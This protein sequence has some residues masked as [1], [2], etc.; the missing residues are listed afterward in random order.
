[1]RTVC[2]VILAAL[3]AVSSAA[4]E[5]L[6]PAFARWVQEAD[7][8]AAE[9]HAFESYLQQQSVGDVLPVSQLLLNATSWRGCVAAPYS[10]P[11]RALWP[12]VV[13]T[14]RFIR[15]HI[16]PAL[17][18][19]S[20]VSGYR[21]PELNACAGGA[22]HSAHALYFALD[23]VPLSAIDRRA[24]IAAVCRVHARFGAAS[25][26]GLGFYQG[27]RFHIDTHGFR[28]WGADWHSATSPCAGQHITG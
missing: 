25:H 2:S 3:I 5:P 26:V 11:P 6:D 15:D 13:P 16:V 1:M 4:A 17:G 23:L 12:N 7:G 20:A 9:V 18:P 28:R 10:L 24:M 19:V 22:T 14:L 8:R 21:E 27:L